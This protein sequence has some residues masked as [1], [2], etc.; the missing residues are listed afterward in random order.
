LSSFAS[1]REKIYCDAQMSSRHIRTFCDL[2]A[3]CERLEPAMTQQGLSC[4][5]AHNRILKVARTIA[6]IEDTPNIEPKPIV[7]A[8]QY[9]ARPHLLDPRTCPGFVASRFKRPF[10]D[11][12]V[13]FVVGIWG[14]GD[15]LPYPQIEIRSIDSPRDDYFLK[16]LVPVWRLAR[17]TV[18]WRGI[19]DPYPPH[20]L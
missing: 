5:R 9:L 12:L 2:S 11:I 18:V 19:I 8:I 13:K 3:D 4:A 14:C 17:D 10:P 7:E 16:N 6:D 20:M 1:S 15:Q